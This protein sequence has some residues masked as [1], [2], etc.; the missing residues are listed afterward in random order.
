M[1]LFSACAA[2]P[3]ACAFCAAQTLNLMPLIARRNNLWQPRCEFGILTG[4]GDVPGL[5]VAI[6][7]AVMR[8]AGRDI[9]VVGLR[10]GWMSML[11]LTPSDPTAAEK[12]TIPLDAADIP[13]DRPHGRHHPA[14]LAH[15]SQQRQGRR[16]SRTCCA[17]AKR[18]VNA[19]HIDCTPHVLRVLEHLGI[20]ALI[21]IGGDDTLSF[22]V[23]L[24]QE[25]FPRGRHPEDD[26]QRRV[27]HRLLHRLLHGRHPLAWRL[28]TAFRTRGRARTSASASSSCSAATP[29][30]R[31]SSPPTSP[32]WTAR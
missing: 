29:G 13:D 18:P 1:V 25:G 6:K 24:H 23:R 30:R 10:R 14:H 32:T 15:Q 8:A 5:N 9:S 17:R 3:L 2:R 11:A 26:G 20:D 19:R 16:T 12:W 21:P 22:A 31:R 4:G 7:A 27:R 28:I